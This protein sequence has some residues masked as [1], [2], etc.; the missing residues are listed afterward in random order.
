MIMD[1]QSILDSL[2]ALNST[3][4]YI[5]PTCNKQRLVTKKT[6]IAKPDILQQCKWCK[7][8][9]NSGKVAYVCP[10]CKKERHETAARLEKR[11]ELKEKCAICRRQETLKKNNLAKYGVEN[12]FQLTDRVKAGVKAKYG[13]ENISQLQSIQ[14]Q[15]LQTLKDRYGEDATKKIS[16]KSHSHTDEKARAKKASETMKNK[17][18]AEKTAIKQKAKDTFIE[19]YGTDYYKKFAKKRKATLK[20]RY[21]KE[22]YSQTADWKKRIDYFWHPDGTSPD[23]KAITPEQR[24]ELAKK[25]YHRYFFDNEYFDSKPELAFYIDMKDA[26]HK[27]DRAAASFSY[28]ADGKSFIYEPDFQV[29]GSLV[30][31][32][33]GQFLKEDGTWQNP[34]DHSQDERYEAKHQCAVA[35]NVRIVYDYG[36]YVDDVNEKYS[37]DFM[38]LF[39][40]L[41]PFPYKNADFADKS[42]SGIMYHF[43]KS[44]YE[45]SKAGKPSP[46]DGW[47]NKE[48]VY[49]VALNRLQEIGHCEPAAIRRGMSIT[50]LAPTVSIF[51]PSL[52]KKLI[53]KYLQDCKTI[54]DPFSGFSGRLLGAVA[55]GK[56]YAGKDLNAKHVQESNE[57][58]KYKNAQNCSVSVEDILKKENIESFDALFTC[59]PYSDKENWNGTKDISKSC[60]GW[61]DICMQT[62]KCKK[63][64]FVVDETE[65]Y[66]DNIVETVGKRNSMFK[67]KGE[68]IILIKN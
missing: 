64:L 66:K 52:A 9:S 23:W 45:A 19:K 30:E 56:S 62:Y 26:G 48:L 1:V 14:Q 41:Q 21:G 8:S 31:L 59:P 7:Q 47:N 63:Y 49:K 24:L 39:D 33:G 57:I 44:I 54:V 51:T 15:R 4:S 53:N 38:D 68:S 67:S 55:C 32:K 5:C 18:L 35:N 3:Y 28:D 17:S 11:P 16:A 58:I 29:D 10:I 36:E 6:I 12:T 20:E 42:D 60:D 13:V 61:I 46:I 65:K 34:F 27:I 43:H 50:R 2:P 40:L 22:F 25:R 37:P